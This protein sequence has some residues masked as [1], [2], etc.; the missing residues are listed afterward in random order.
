MQDKIDQLEKIYRE[1]QSIE[2]DIEGFSSSKSAY[3]ANKPNELKELIK[4]KK[5]SLLRRQERWNKLLLSMRI[6][7]QP[8][9]LRQVSMKLKK[10]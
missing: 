6:P 3:Y 5:E 7:I 4:S 8:D 10:Q 2:T 9:K 1:I